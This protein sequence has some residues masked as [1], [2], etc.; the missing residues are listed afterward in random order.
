MS[1]QEG[2]FGLSF[3][4]RPR[5]PTLALIIQI[6]EGDH[7]IA[8]TF[9][10][11]ERIGAVVFVSDPPWRSD[12][13]QKRITD[14]DVTRCVAWLEET[15][16]APFSYDLVFKA[17]QAVAVSA[18]FDPVRVYLESIQWDGKVRI[19]DWLAKIMG[20][21]D[22]TWTRAVGKAWLISA[23]AR[24]FQPG[25]QA[26]HV[27]VLEGPQGRGKSKALRTLGGE[28]FTDDLPDMH[29]KDASQA[30]GAAW[31]VELAELAATRRSDQES[32]KAFITRTV[33][34]FR[35]PWGRTVVEAPRR[36]VFAASTNNTEW[37][38]DETGGRR[39][40]PVTIGEDQAR[41]DL[42]AKYRD[43]LWA[44]AVVRYRAGE[45][46]HLVEADL[47]GRA[48]QQQETR[49]ILDPWEQKIEDFLRNR[50]EVTSQELLDMLGLDVA[51]QTRG[52]MMRVGRILAAFKRIRVRRRKDGRQT[53]VY[54][55][56]PSG[57]A[58]GGAPLL[59]E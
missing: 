41:I 53:W 59:P 35:P 11:N 9:A 28:W 32:I 36:C 37:L 56:N 45:P 24:T 25:C 44:E 21:E 17:I 7:R 10:H 52:D 29:S 51:R 47:I 30:V 50:D 1:E 2:T 46:W 14:E 4:S 57:K 3:G 49:R 39:Y 18:A 12:A 8:R 22:S 54:I 27:L 43:Q 15:Y 6:L 20:A 23:V 38:Q 58:G 40:W 16:S 48:Q 55:E 5:R 19:D 33:D 42:L 26:D 13:F 31:I 34:R